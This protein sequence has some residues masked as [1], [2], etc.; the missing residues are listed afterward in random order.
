[1]GNY[2]I[3]LKFENPRRGRQARNFSENDPKILDL[4]S[5]SEQIIFRK[6]SLV[7]PEEFNSYIVSKFN[8]KKEYRTC[9]LCKFRKLCNPYNFPLNLIFPQALLDRYWPIRYYNKSSKGKPRRNKLFAIF[10]AV[11]VMA[12]SYHNS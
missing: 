1:M 9:V 3:V 2:T 4:K 7:A 6:L 11:S 8:K 10:L 12:C 5:S